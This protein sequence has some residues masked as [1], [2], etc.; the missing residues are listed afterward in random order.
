MW[1]FK[2][3]VILKI[4]NLFRDCQR[5][6]IRQEKLKIYKETGVWP[7]TQQASKR[8]SCKQTEPWSLSKQRKI[9]RKNKRDTRK[10]KKQ[11]QRDSGVTKRKRKRNVCQEDI[12]ELAKDIALIKKLKQKKVRMVKYNCWFEQYFASVIVCTIVLHW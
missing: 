8:T 11:Q 1:L 2:Q 12:D 7:K 5:E 6:Q 9:E 10:L 4:C 3:Q